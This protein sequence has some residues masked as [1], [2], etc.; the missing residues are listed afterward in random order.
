[1]DHSTLVFASVF[2]VPSLSHT[3]PTPIATPDLGSTAP[4]ASFGSPYIANTSG[5]QHRLAR[6]NLAWSTAT[7]FL[8]LPKNALDV[9]KAAKASP[10][11]EEALSYLLIGEGT[12]QD[13]EEGIADWFANETRL[14][15]ANHG[16]R[17]LLELWNE[18]STLRCYKNCC[19]SPLTRVAGG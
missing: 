8:S 12:S 10:D 14:H 4:G 6:R 17:D 1:M 5:G 16:S 15:F 2:P 3:T 18:V 13:R 19:S 9:P 11:V 7:R